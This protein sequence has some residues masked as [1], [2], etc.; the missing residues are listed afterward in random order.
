MPK[1][2]LRL[3]SPNDAQSRTLSLEA[4]D[5]PTARKHAEQAELAVVN[6]SLLPPKKDVW[7]SPP[8]GPDSPDGLVD[9]SRWDA[10]DQKFAKYAA[11]LP[12]EDAV[13][14]AK[15]RLDRLHSRVDVRQDGKVRGADLSPRAVGRVLAHRQT[16]PY[17]V[18]EVR[19]V[20]AAEIDAQRLVRQVAAVKGNPAAWERM[21]DA[22]REAG[23]PMAAVTAALNG[24]PVQKQ[25]DG[26]STFVY[27]S[28][29]FRVILNTSYTANN[30]THDFYDDASGTEITGTGYTAKGA[31]LA[32]K[33]STYDTATDQVRL[34]AADT[35]WTTSTLSATDANIFT[36]T[37]GASSTDPLWGNI[38]FG[39]TVSTTA[40]TFQITWD[41]TGIMVYDVT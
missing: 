6:F 19:E 24:L 16:E 13:S 26:S 15:R 14:A 8:G 27:S 17:A 30:D 35:T 11:T 29:D 28:G 18:T 3:E 34:D 20:S 39:A 33:T 40:G 38:D 2:E 37:A 22:L 25:L 32:S 7:E 23:V 5:E 36:D 1:Y 21:L 4:P 9:L 10:Y 31:A 41:A 12:Y